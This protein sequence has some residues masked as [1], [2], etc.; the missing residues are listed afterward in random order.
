MNKKISVADFL[1]GNA[2][3]VI[4]QKAVAGILQERNYLYLGELGIGED[5]SIFMHRFFA[6]LQDKNI[7]LASKVCLVIRIPVF[8]PIR[9]SEMEELVSFFSSWTNKFEIYW[10]LYVVDGVEGMQ[11]AVLADETGVEQWKGY[12]QG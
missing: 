3:I 1:T 10:G 9:L 12:G 4:P 2:M 5:T 7:T 6:S 8:R 11:I